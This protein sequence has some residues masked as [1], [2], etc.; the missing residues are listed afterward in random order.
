MQKYVP[1][2][3]K[4][5]LKILESVNQTQGHYL[6]TNLQKSK[7]L[8]EIKEKPMQ[9]ELF[10]VILYTLRATLHLSVLTENETRTIE[11]ITKQTVHIHEGGFLQF[12]IF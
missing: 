11:I 3:S 6:H 12:L 2:I 4:H 7:S 5:I 1:E 10:R 9:L 8:A